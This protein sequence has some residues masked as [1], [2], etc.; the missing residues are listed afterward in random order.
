MSKAQEK[1]EAMEAA[2]AAGELSYGMHTHQELYAYRA[3]YNAMAF[4]LAAQCGAFPVVKSWRHADGKLCFGGGWFIVV[5]SLPQGQVANHYKNSEW[6]RFR[7]P[8]VD[9]APE[10]DGHSAQEG[11]R[12]LQ[13]WLG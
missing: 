7:V 2:L 4:N 13:A 6:N 5:A 9:R 3:A 1:L 10:W 11:L 8:S 12:R